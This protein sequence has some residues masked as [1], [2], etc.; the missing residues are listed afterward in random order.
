M[1][2]DP[3]AQGPG[4]LADELGDLLF[5]ILF[6]A[7]VGQEENPA[8]DVD[9]VA[10]AF[11]EKM[12]RRNP[13]VFGTGRE[14]SAR[15]SRGRRS[16]HRPVACGQIRGT[17]RAG[18]AAQGLVRRDPRRAA[19]AAERREGGP[20]CPLRGTAR[21]A[22]RRRRRSRRGAGRLAVGRGPRPR[23]ARSRGRRGV[24]GR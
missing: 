23:P 12:E 13:H 9:D 15:G 22:A 16:D 1:I 14:G 2:D 17:R 11:V 19:C 18:R 5:Q 3:D 4:A 20:P 7:R 8:W 10:R 21:G 6:H 24:P